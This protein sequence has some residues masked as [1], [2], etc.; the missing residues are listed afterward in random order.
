MHAPFR[1]RGAPG[2]QGPKRR[3]GH[4][5]EPEDRDHGAHDRLEAGRCAVQLGFALAGRPA[6]V[7]VGLPSYSLRHRSSRTRSRFRSPRFV[8]VGPWGVPSTI[9]SSEWRGLDRR[10]QLSNPRPVLGRRARLI[11]DIRHM[12]SAHCRES[13]D[14][15]SER[16]DL[17]TRNNARK[18]RAIGKAEEDLFGSRA[19]PL[20]GARSSP[21]TSH[22]LS[23]S[24][25]RTNRVLFPGDMVRTCAVRAG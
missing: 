12:W 18:S 16:S 8:R 24:S 14:D 2:P 22:V 5:A 15:D 25:P 7:R 19:A 1:C 11:R 21:A 23:R 9:V 4:G 17:T 10:H 13:V 3:A 20:D 6:A